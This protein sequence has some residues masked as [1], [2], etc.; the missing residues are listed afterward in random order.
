MVDELNALIEHNERQA[1][2]ARRHAGNLAHALKTPLTVIMN[3]A[4]ADANDLSDTVCR[5]ARTM[6]VGKVAR[7]TLLPGR[8]IPAN[9]IGEPRLITV[10]A[11]VRVVYEEGGLNIT[12]YGSALQPGIVLPPVADPILRLWN[13]VTA[14]SVVLERQEAALRGSG[15]P[16]Y[17]AHRS[18]ASLHAPTPMSVAGSKETL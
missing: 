9:A 18:S 11:R 2:E 4:T 17:G 13:A 3:A 8:A 5:E 14:G 7:R 6:L 1:E 12:A 16:A 15:S 10:G